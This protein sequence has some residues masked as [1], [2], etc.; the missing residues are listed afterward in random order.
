MKMTY[1][2]NETYLDDA[3]NNLG[4]MFDYAV[5]ECD[6]DA[7]D[8]LNYFIISGVASSFGRGN[9][10]YVAGVSGPELASEV[11]YRTFQTR[12][13]IEPAVVIEKSPEY[14]A[15]WI[16]AYYQWFTN[17]NFSDMK[18][19]GLDMER[20]LELYPT[21]HEADV[22][23]FVSVANNITAK[24]AAARISNLKKIRKARG[25]TQ[26]QLAEASGVALRMI[27]LYEQR[28]QDI[29]KAQAVSLVNMARV[30]GCKVDDLLA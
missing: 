25:M 19:N 12:P 5:N 26:K 17:Q 13:N 8:F 15:G 20:L 11:I 10:K 7:E 21:L 2:Y 9:P 24:N 22:S 1:A 23:K 16:M 27:Q 29:G 28:R 30:L 3:M 18:E 14:W 6:Y 4:D